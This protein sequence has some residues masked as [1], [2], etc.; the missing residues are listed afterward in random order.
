[1]KTISYGNQTPGG[2]DWLFQVAFDYGDLNTADPIGVAPIVWSGRPDPFSD[3]RSTF[4][5]RTYRL[6]QR[7]LMLHNFAELSGWTVARSTDFLYK[8]NPV[9]TTLSS[10]TQNGWLKTGSTYATLPLPTLTMTYSEAVIEP[11][12]HTADAASLAHLP[13]GVDGKNYQL[14]DLDGEGL[15]GVLTQQGTGLFYDRP[16]GNGS[17]APPARLSRPS[18][19]PA[20]GTPQLADLDGSGHRFLVQLDRSP[21]GYF[22]RFGDQW[23]TFRPFQ[24]KPVGGLLN[25]KVEYVD[26]DGDGLPDILKP[27]GELYRWWPSLGKEGY[28][29]E[30]RTTQPRDERQAP[31]VVW[32]DPRQAVLLADMTG[33]GLSDVVRVTAG[34]VS[35]WPN[36]GYGRFGA[37][38]TMKDAPLLGSVA[39]FN[40][41]LVRL[42]DIDGSGTADL[43][44]LESG[45]ARVWLN[46]AGNGYGSEQRVPFPSPAGNDVTVTDL[47]GNGTACLVWSSP[48]PGNRGAQLRYLDL[49]SGTK[50]YLL[51]TVTNNLGAT[52]TITYQSSTAYYLADRRAGLPWVTKLPFVM[53]VVATVEVDESVTGT[54]MVTT[55]QYHHGHYDGVEREFAG[56]GMVEQTD[57]ETLVE[58]ATTFAYTPPKLTKSWFHTGAFFD[59]ET[60]S[61]QYAREYSTDFPQLVP[62]SLL[63][64][65]VP[66]EQMREAARALRGHL[67]RQ[68][69]YGL[70]SSALA[71]HPYAIT[72]S[73]FQVRWLQP[74]ATDHYGS[75]DVIPRETLTVHTERNAADPR[76]EHELTMNVDAYGNVVEGLHIAYARAGADPTSAQAVTLI[77]DAQVDYVNIDDATDNYRVGLVR[78]SRKY[79]LTGVSA[80]VLEDTYSFA[81]AQALLTATRTLFEQTRMIYLGDSP[82]DNSQLALGLATDTHRAAFPDTLF[83]TVYGTLPAAP[84]PTL[85][86]YLSDSTMWWSPTGQTTYL[87]GQFYLPQQFTDPFGTINTIAYDTYSLLPLS[88]VQASNTPYKTTTSITNDYRVLAPT[89]LV[90]ANL[91]QTQVAFDALG[92]VVSTW[93]MGKAIESIGDDAAHPSTVI[94][95]HTDVVPAYVKVTKREQHYLT[96][97]TNTKT[98]IAYSYT[99]GL[100]RDVL[101]KKQAQPDSSG[102]PRW[103][104]AGRTVFDNKGNP[105]QKFEPYFSANTDFE[106][107]FNGVSD[108]LTYD[109][110]NRVV[111]TDHPNGS[112]SRVQLGELVADVFTPNAWGQISYDENDTVG[113]TG[114]AWYAAFITG[115]A[116]QIDAAKKALAHNDT[117]TRTHVDPLGRTYLTEQD[118]GGG[119]LFATTLA[120]DLEGNPLVVTDARSVKV[121]T[122]TFDLLKRTMQV[123]SP[124]SGTQTSLLDVTGKPIYEWTANGAQVARAYDPLRRPASVTVTE[125]TGT[126]IVERAFYGE[127]LANAASANLNGKLYRQLD[128]AGL[129]TH[130]A[131]DFKGNLLTSSRQLAATY[132]FS[133]I[134]WPVLADLTAIDPTWL[135]AGVLSESFATAIAYDALNRQTRIEMDRTDGTS[136]VAVPTYNE[137]GLLSGMTAQVAGA[138]SPSAYVAR[139]DYNEKE[140]RLAIAYGNGVSTAY[141]YEP[142]TFRLSTLQTTKST[143]G[144]LQSLGYTYDPVGNITTVEDTA[145]QTLYVGN[146]K[147]KPTTTYTYD[148]IYRLTNAVGRE[149]ITQSTPDQ[150]FTPPWITLPNPNDST[151]MRNYAESYQYD[152]VGNFIAM[153]HAVTNNAGQYQNLWTRTYTTDAAS[154]RLQ[155]TILGNG[156]TANTNYVY[157]DGVANG[158]GNI[159]TMSATSLVWDYKNQLIQATTSQG[160]SHFQYDSAGQRVRKTLIPGTGSITLTERFYLAGYELYRE[161]TTSATTASLERRTLDIVDG[162]RKI[163]LIEILTSGSDGS[164]SRLDRYQLDN[165]LGSAVLEID[166]S[167][168]TISYEEYHPYGTTAYLAGQSVLGTNPKRYA[169]AGKE[170]DDE[171]GFYYHGARYYMPWLGRWVNPDPAWSGD[172]TPP[173]L[174]TSDNPVGRVDDDGMEDTTVTEPTPPNVPA[175]FLDTLPSSPAIPGHDPMEGIDSEYVPPVGAPERGRRGLR[176]EELGRTDLDVTFRGND[177]L[178]TRTLDVATKLDIDPGLLA[179]TLLAEELPGTW[180]KKT[181]NVAS[182]V[183]GIDDWFDPSFSSY[184]K[185]VISDHPELDVKYGDV[186]KTGLQWDSG[187]EKAGGAL[188]DRGLVA[189]TKA[190]A[191]AGIYLKAQQAQLERVIANRAASSGTTLPALSTLSPEKQLTVQRLVVNAGVV[192]AAALYERLAA[193]GDIPRAGGT[194]RNTSNPARTAVLHVARAIHLDQAVFARPSGRY[195]P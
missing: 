183:L 186:A 157:D 84:S 92:R 184:I 107:V 155:Q 36:R 135:P 19:T 150:T 130:S 21:A 127:P 189:G 153:V 5:V 86:G 188:K 136:D 148:A 181:G 55:Y 166:G 76:R 23:S 52:T 141:T 163:A 20:G 68:E 144:D 108:L 173:Y 46:Q 50:P 140:Q 143:A 22:E 100:G 62:D 81:E 27:E 44:Y 71:P 45:V 147:I 116:D 171:T 3:F 114:N 83:Q 106:V 182:E 109:P 138:A 28:G 32:T 70:D 103:T 152:D 193:G 142:T 15:P 10:V 14:V 110:L 43:M 49:M 133:Q 134:S 4:E 119:A 79:Q 98:Q 122:T 42:A 102:N 194:Q 78:E 75:F 123:I 29:Q 93:V 176:P 167:A 112:Y 137:T 115:T 145:Q 12:L 169:Y 67:L 164:P 7:V 158:A 128:G 30:R 185:S 65:S 73:N 11:T 131:Y 80:P 16:T 111:R 85:G 101:T 18:L 64:R 33:D 151:A 172:A 9:A 38:V 57:A 161:H 132:D 187:L 149:H 91:N 160:T 105:V 165:H 53:Q 180:T 97:P 13:M 90:D 95:Y 82:A 72:E 129:V 8:P 124:D 139:I 2:S 6:C 69:I 177:T 99:D 74:R 94:E 1:M 125:S 48:L 159:T 34:S 66:P 61:T 87:T 77:T 54:K 56:F 179:A 39:D 156:T 118:N 120:L 25:A 17:F 178:R 190:V 59:A 113:E 121:A 88:A 41:A 195:R 175:N 174:F 154:N 168:T 117:P 192:P 60:V 47:L 170:R 191:V 162:K 31:Y 96:D 35:Y 24:K 40:P 126:R 146:S 51:L 89:L 104:G 63:P 37:R 58:G 26:L